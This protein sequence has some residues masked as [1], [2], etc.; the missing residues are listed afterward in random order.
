V[1]FFVAIAYSTKPVWAIQPIGDDKFIVLTMALL[2]CA[3]V[4]IAP[5]WIAM[6][7]HDRPMP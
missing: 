4:S 6:R 2:N 7:L 1:L 3:N 5:G